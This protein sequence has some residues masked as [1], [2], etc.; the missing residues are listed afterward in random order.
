MASYS[1]YTQMVDGLLPDGIKPKPETMSPYCK[2]DINSK[3]YKRVFTKNAFENVVFKFL[4]ISLPAQ[5]VNSPLS[6][7]CSA[8]I[9]RMMS[10]G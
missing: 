1:S 8:M 5:W 7:A 10:L 4:A 3:K 6:F 2:L 9:S